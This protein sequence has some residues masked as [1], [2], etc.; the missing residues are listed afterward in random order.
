MPGRFPVVQV[1]PLFSEVANAMSDAP[2]SKN[3]PVCTTETMVDPN[4]NESG[5]TWVRC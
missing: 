1:V 4:E 5:S 3:R 2:P